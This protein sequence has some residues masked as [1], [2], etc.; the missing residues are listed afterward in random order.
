MLPIGQV[1][2]PE[3]KAL[4]EKVVERCEAQ[5]ADVLGV[6]EE[7]WNIHYYW[8]LAGLAYCHEQL[9]EM[10]A[11]EAVYRKMAHREAG[12]EESM[13]SRFFRI[14]NRARA[15]VKPTAACLREMADELDK[16]ALAHRE[17]HGSK[18]TA[19]LEK[20]ERQARSFRERATA[21]EE[22]EHI[23]R[24]KLN[25]QEHDGKGK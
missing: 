1:S 18:W 25:L 23:G 13:V 19:F 10:A 24:H 14:V 16:V 22:N 15:Q 11:A 3:A 6:S 8:S 20:V 4:F 7:D 17:R 21:V 12:E 5:S 9:G 2:I